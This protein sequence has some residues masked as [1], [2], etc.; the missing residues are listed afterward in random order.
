MSI[1]A[2]KSRIVVK[3]WYALKWAQ[4]DGATGCEGFVGGSKEDS[5][6]EQDKPIEDSGFGLMPR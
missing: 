3:N 4:S 5:P 2:K 6:P 1:L